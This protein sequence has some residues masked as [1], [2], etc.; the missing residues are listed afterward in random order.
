MAAGQCMWKLLKVIYCAYIYGNERTC[1]P[2]QRYGL[3]IQITV[4]VTVVVIVV[5]QIFYSTV[6]KSHRVCVFLCAFL[7]SRL[8]IAHV[9]IDFLLLLQLRHTY[10]TVTFIL[11]FV[12]LTEDYVVQTRS[13]QHAGT[14][15]T[16]S[17]ALHCAEDYIIPR[18]TYSSTG[19][20]QSLLAALTQEP[21][22]PSCHIFVL[23]CF[24]TF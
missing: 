22:D 12:I 24:V 1:H 16:L 9:L 3:L 15:V 17:A 5:V 14:I 19:I 11:I 10:I 18:Q 8:L 6:C 13:N 20:P 2:V 4:V 23:G 7:C 21:L